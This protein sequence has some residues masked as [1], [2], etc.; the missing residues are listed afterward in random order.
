MVGDRGG[1]RAEVLKREVSSWL[2]LSPAAFDRLLA[3][4]SCGMVAFLSA[5]LGPGCLE[6]SHAVDR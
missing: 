1:P 5:L 6:L 3:W 4:S 2:C